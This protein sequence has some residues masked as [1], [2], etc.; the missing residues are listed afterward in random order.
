MAG[1]IRALRASV[2]AMRSARSLGAKDAIALEGL[3]THLDAVKTETGAAIAELAGK[4]EHMQRE[5]T[6]KFSQVSERFDRPRHQ[7]VAPL[8]TASRADASASKVGVVQ[9]QAKNRR[10]DAFDPSQNPGAPGVPRP[11]AIP[12]S[13]GER[14]LDGRAA[15]AAR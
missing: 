4:V 9:K 3:K 7:I 2:E 11:L 8:A 6:A 13:G 14:E 15:S 1:E 12:A 5:T 10:G